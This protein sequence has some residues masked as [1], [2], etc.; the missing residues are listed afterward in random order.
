MV[1]SLTQGLRHYGV[2]PDTGTT[3]R[4]RLVH[5]PDDER[6]RLVHAPDDE[7]ER[8]VHAPDDERERLVHAPDDEQQ[9]TDEADSCAARRHVRS[10]CHVQV[11]VVRLTP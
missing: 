11:L 1:Y 3:G 7:R 5:A 4:E 9:T 2:Q 8:L 6:E 10:H